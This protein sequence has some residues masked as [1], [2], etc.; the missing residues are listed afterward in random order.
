VDLG[1]MRVF[2]TSKED[3]LAVSSPLIEFVWFAAKHFMA[4]IFGAYTET[5]T[6]LGILVIGCVVLHVMFKEKN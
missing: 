3:L 6:Y 4:K 2:K 1:E 5:A